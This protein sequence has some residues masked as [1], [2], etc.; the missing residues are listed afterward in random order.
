MVRLP[1]PGWS[2]RRGRVPCAGPHRRGGVGHSRPGGGGGA[3]SGEHGRSCGTAAPGLP[4]SGDATPGGGARRA[5]RDVDEH[6]RCACSAATRHR[7]GTAAGTDW[8]DPG[9]VS[10]SGGPG[11]GFTWPGSGHPGGVRPPV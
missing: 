4:R 1:Y 10:R 9:A 6:P 5:L 2:G 3:E 11:P 7:A 8:R